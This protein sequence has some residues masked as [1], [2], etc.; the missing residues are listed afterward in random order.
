[1]QLRAD[2]YQHALVATVNVHLKSFV[3]LEL[4]F[5]RHHIII[6]REMVSQNERNNQM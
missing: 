2:N 5:A 3:V 1:M 4:L 6:I